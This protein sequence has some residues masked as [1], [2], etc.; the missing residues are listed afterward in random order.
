MTPIIPA[1]NTTWFWFDKKNRR[2]L[3]GTAEDVMRKFDLISSRCERLE[4][5]EIFLLCVRNSHTSR[6]TFD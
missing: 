5:L 4:G 2:K 6:R 1:M 3:H